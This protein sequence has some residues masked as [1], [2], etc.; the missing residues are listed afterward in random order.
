MGERV[1]YAKRILE[2]VTDPTGFL[3]SIS[4]GMAQNHCRLPWYA[5]L[6]E[7]MCLTQHLQGVHFHGRLLTIYRTFH[8]VS[9][10]V[11]L[12]VH[13]WLLSL[14]K[15]F[16]LEGCLPDTLYHQIDGGCENTAR[17]MK[18]LCELLIIRG[19]TKKLCLHD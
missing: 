3:S 10:G 18:G 6:K 14:E 8:N 12:G 13:S 15:I 4:D 9:N 5:N 19:L 7:G 17:T 16:N 11:N 1:S 2:A